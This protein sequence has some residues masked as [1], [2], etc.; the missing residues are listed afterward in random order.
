MADK[1]DIFQLTTVK[2]KI[3]YGAITKKVVDR[4]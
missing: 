1:L 2:A 3:W 4:F